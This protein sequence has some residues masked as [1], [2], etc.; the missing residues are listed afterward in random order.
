M[1]IKE[2]YSYIMPFISSYI[3][4][5]D[6]E[7]V[8]AAKPEIGTEVELK[9]PIVNTESIKLIKQTNYLDLLRD[10]IQHIEIHD[11][12]LPVFSSLF[13]HDLIDVL[14]Q[15]ITVEKK[16][17]ETTLDENESMIKI[18][19]NPIMY[20]ILYGPI[21][22]IHHYTIITLEQFSKWFESKVSIFLDAKSGSPVQNF[23]QEWC[24]ERLNEVYRG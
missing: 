8:F 6:I 24:F 12:I 14:T 21:S 15:L 4:P 13:T 2:I 20:G 17:I 9:L 16:Y 10:I 19:M 22:E 1:S 7:E 23:I 5:I 18:K 11:D 3:N